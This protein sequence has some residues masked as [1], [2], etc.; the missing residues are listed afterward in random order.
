MHLRAIVLTLFPEM[1]PG[2]LGCSLAGQ[3]LAK[4]VWELKALNIRDFAENKH[5]TV[6]DKPYG[7]GTGMVL[8]PDVLEKAI[9]DAKGLL[10]NAKLIY[11]TPRGVPLTQGLVV[12]LLQ[13][14]AH[15]SAPPLRGSSQD[16]AQAREGR[17]VGGNDAAYTPHDSAIA[18]SAPPQ[19]GSEEAEKFGIY[20][21]CNR[22]ETS[23]HGFA[24]AIFAAARAKGM[25]LKV[26]RV[27]PIETCEYPTPA[28]RPLNSRLNCTHAKEQLGITLPAWQEGLSACMEEKYG[29]A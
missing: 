19:G 5:K 15:I 4:G 20:H 27:V 10:P 2:P 9:L 14:D 6:D 7:G 8:K 23:W 17:G 13:N 18:S 1:F 21:L 24:E 11:F 12:K 22:G 29:S 25:E 16:Q 3:A 28:Q 26:K